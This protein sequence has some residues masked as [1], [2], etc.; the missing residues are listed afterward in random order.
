MPGAVAW[1]L[2]W[3]NHIALHVLMYGACAC[4]LVA[5]ESCVACEIMPCPLPR[6]A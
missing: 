1:W 5:G 4:P 6:T 3:R 2:A